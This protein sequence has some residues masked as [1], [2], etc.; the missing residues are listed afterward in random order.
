MTKV[1]YIILLFSLINT[2][3]RTIESSKGHFYGI[4]LPPGDDLFEQISLFTRNNNITAASIIS[5]SGSLKKVSLRFANQQNPTI[6]EGF[7]EIV[8]F[9][10][11]I[12]IFGNHL[13]MSVSNSK[14]LTIGGHVGIGN[15]VYTTVEIV[16]AVLDDL[17][18]KR[19]KCELSGYL[20][21][22]VEKK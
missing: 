11:T 14:G 20:E 10:G 18:F 1:L 7:H 22:F 4:R 12:S 3:H 21:L 9:S 8:S 2:Q 15:I 5:C 6:I 19:K 16:I 13:H 17:N